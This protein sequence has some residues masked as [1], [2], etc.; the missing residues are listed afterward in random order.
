MASWELHRRVLFELNRI[1]SLWIILH[2]P[3]G[4]YYELSHLLSAILGNHDLD[5][6]TL[7]TLWW[8]GV[9]LPKRQG[10]GVTR[11]QHDM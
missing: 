4:L 2:L 9:V 5:W 6:V 11:I 8:C 7:R 1:S 10:V 3:L